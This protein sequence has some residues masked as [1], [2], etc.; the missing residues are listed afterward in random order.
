MQLLSAISILTAMLLQPVGRYMIAGSAFQK[1]GQRLPDK[2]RSK[3]DKFCESF[4]KVG[5]MPHVIQHVLLMS[6]DLPH[7]YA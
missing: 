3:I 7:M 6:C 4:W 5:H 2:M 1:S